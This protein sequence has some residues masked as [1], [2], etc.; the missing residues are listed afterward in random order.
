M[1]WTSNFSFFIKE[2]W[3]CTMIKHH[4]K[5]ILLTRNLPFDSDIKQWCH[6]LA[7]PL[8][9]LWAESNNRTRC[10]FEYDATLVFLFVCLV[11]FINMHSAVVVP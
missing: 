5:N 10:Q 7:I 6:L 2:N 1:F 9:Y 3:I 8:R 11:S 4:A